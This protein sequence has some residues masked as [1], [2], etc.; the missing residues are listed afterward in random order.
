MGLS[1][2]PDFNS[3]SLTVLLMCLTFGPMILIGLSIISLICCLFYYFPAFM[4]PMLISF[5]V[6]LFAYIGVYE[7][8]SRYSQA[9]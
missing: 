2:A 5:L 4:V 1:N 8:H 9:Q 7:L 6:L 3:W